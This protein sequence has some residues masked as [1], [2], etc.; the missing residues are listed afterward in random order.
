MAKCLL[1]AMRYAWRR[2]RFRRAW[3]A[4]SR[5]FGTCRNADVPGV[6]TPGY[7]HDVPPGQRTLSN[8]TTGIPNRSAA[9]ETNVQTPGGLSAPSS[10]VFE[11]MT[12]AQ[13]LIPGLLELTGHAPP[14][15]CESGLRYR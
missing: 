2:V 13:Q 9:L 4:F 10:G 11:L 12:W 14:A 8:G 15:S 1:W 6:E 7:S 5:P 3:T